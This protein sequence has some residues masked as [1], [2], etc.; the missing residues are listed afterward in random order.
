MEEEKNQAQTQTQTQLRK[1]S[2][3]VQNGIHAKSVLSNIPL[4]RVR[5][6]TQNDIP[7]GYVGKYSDGSIAIEKLDTDILITQ[8]YLYICNIIIRSAYPIE[9]ITLHANDVEL[10][11]A[12][13]L[14][15]REERVYVYVFSDFWYIRPN[16]GYN[17]LSLVLSN[18]TD[19]EELPSMMYDAVTL[20]DVDL[21]WQ[22]ECAKHQIFELGSSEYAVINLCGQGASIFD[23]TRETYQPVNSARIISLRALAIIQKGAILRNSRYRA[24]IIT[25]IVAIRNGWNIYFKQASLDDFKAM[26][27]ATSPLIPTTI[28]DD[29]F[30]RTQDGKVILHTDDFTSD[31]KSPE[32]GI[33][34]DTFDMIG[35]MYLSRLHQGVTESDTL[36]DLTVPLF[37]LGVTFQDAD[38]IIRVLDGTEFKFTKTDNQLIM[39]NNEI[40]ASV[41]EYKSALTLYMENFSEPLESVGVRFREDNIHPDLTRFVDERNICYVFWDGLSYLTHPLQVTY[42]M[43]GRFID[44]F[45]TAL[46][47]EGYCI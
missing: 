44:A 43:P 46:C 3:Y 27:M 19:G 32:P 8:D 18:M 38:I 6:N 1:L 20:T 13:L 5:N 24:K 36:V 12:T 47:D 23:F 29:G 35:S 42:K 30:I 16:D 40:V 31:E 41:I 7:E 2:T 33:S 22:V 45:T 14:D 34:I 11:K 25:K 26:T 17:N 10:A 21:R 28:D 37:S 39:Y 15:S 4:F 9:S